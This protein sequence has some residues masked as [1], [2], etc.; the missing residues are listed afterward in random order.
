MF[1][2]WTIIPMVLQLRKGLKLTLGLNLINSHHLASSWFLTRHDG[3][4]LQKRPTRMW[5]DFDCLYGKDVVGRSGMVHSCRRA[6]NLRTRLCRTHKISRFAGKLPFGSRIRTSSSL[7]IWT[8]S[9]IT[10]HLQLPALLQRGW[11]AIVGHT[12]Q[13]YIPSQHTVYFFLFFPWLHDVNKVGFSDE[14]LDMW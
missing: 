1:V 12:N 14:P 9:T 11:P 10:L 5:L 4:K 2:Q 7:V 8:K 13:P 3:P 6:S